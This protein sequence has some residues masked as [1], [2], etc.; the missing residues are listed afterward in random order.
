MQGAWCETQFR[1]SRITPWAKGRHSTT[2]PP[3]HPRLLSFLTNLRGK[4]R[5]A[6]TRYH[7]GLDWQ[8]SH[9]TCSS[10]PPGIHTVFKVT[11]Q[12]W[13]FLFGDPNLSGPLMWGSS[14]R[15]RSGSFLTGK[16]DFSFQW[17]GQAAGG[18]P[19]HHPGTHSL[20]IR[21]MQ[22]KVENRDRKEGGW[23]RKGGWKRGEKTGVRERNA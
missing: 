9:T 10:S 19:C 13:D 15:I 21:P 2:E 8:G 5:H 12:H 6:H 7:T 20:R 1:D 14:K 4:S 22:G 17:A 16:E 23:D 18:H 3:R 11:A